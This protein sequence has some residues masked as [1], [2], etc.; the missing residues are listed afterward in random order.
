MTGSTRRAALVLLAALTGWPG[1]AFAASEGGGASLLWHA[2]NLALLVGVIAYF[3][4]KPIREFMYERRTKIQSELQDAQNQL[5]VAEEKL[6]A[7]Q[8]RIDDLDQELEGIRSAVRTQAEAERERVLR[9]AQDAAERIRRDAQASAEQ[10]LR[11][12]RDRLRDE[13]A[14]LAVK[15]AGELIESQVSAQDQERLV[16]DFI[17]QLEARPPA[18]R[19][20]AAGPET[21]RS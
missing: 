12:A 8:R 10:E 9:D 15:L 7:C 13:T 19:R 2:V 17:T 4:R 11:R 18:R 1:L 21:P 5:T 14:T 20:A 3:A 16:A 6:A